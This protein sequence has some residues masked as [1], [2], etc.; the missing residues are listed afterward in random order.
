MSE[1]RK[2]DESPATR[3]IAEFRSMNPAPT[4]KDWIALIGAHPEVAG[5]IADAALLHRTVQHLD[6]SDL[7]G[8]L[9]REVF[10]S[11][12][13]RAITRLYAIPSA[14]L[15]EAQEKIAAVQGPGVRTLALEVG[16]GSASALLSGILVGAIEVP[17]K[18]LD[19]L[20]VQLG[21][22]AMILME[23][24]Q[25]ARATATV[26]SFKA[27]MEKP[28]LATQPTSWSEAVKSLRLS[29]QETQRLLLLQD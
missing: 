7:D 8:P 6:E 3:I 16:L 9:N 5:E 14:A 4:Q 21:S 18:V 28:G 1:E 11:G 27:E 17:R 20:V 22:T 19:G 26:P 15:R 13:S 25:R 2:R 24:F 10:E 29:E 12:V 23:C